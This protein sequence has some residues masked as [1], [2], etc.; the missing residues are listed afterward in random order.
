MVS[1][2]VFRS[3]ETFTQE[4]FRLWLDERP[5]SDLNHYELLNGRIVMTP[6]AGWPHGRVGR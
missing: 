4:S 5:A 3:D 1:Q 6:P 2:T